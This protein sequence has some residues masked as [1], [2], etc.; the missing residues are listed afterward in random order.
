MR[1]TCPRST[2][3]SE[4]RLTTPAMP[5]IPDSPPP[6]RKGPVVDVDGAPTGADAKTSQASVL[7]PDRPDPGRGRRPAFH[8]KKEADDAKRQR[9]GDSPGGQGSRLLLPELRRQ[10]AAIRPIAAGG[11]ARMQRTGRK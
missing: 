1:I 5:H 9:C 2:R 10:P 3:A 6:D 7:E 11:H 4:A 8:R